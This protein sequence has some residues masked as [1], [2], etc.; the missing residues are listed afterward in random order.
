MPRKDHYHFAV[1]EALEKEGWTITDDPL[2]VQTPGTEFQIDLAAER[3][4]ISA[5]KGGEKI[6][7][8]IKSL[9]G[10]TFF[11]DY[12]Q[13]LGQFL[14]YRIALELVFPD[15]NLFLAIP[16]EAYYELST[17]YAFRESWQRFSVNLLIFNHHEKKI[18][19]WIK[20]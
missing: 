17:S 13:A 8:E 14:V 1:K 19:K 5:E 18:N 3:G 10:H 15:R 7:V 12:Y 9:I 6:V 20:Y 2:T 16:F 4:V 11:Y